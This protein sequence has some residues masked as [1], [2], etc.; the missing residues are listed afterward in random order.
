MQKQ[1]QPFHSNNW[2]YI[3]EPKNAKQKKTQKLNLCLEKKLLKQK[4]FSGRL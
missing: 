3:Q 2:E 1:V 4:R